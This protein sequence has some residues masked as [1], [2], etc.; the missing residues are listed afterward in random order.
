MIYKYKAFRGSEKVKG[1]IEADNLKEAKEKL[2]REGL[3]PIKLS[4]IHI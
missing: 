2:K 1:N 4:L 3:R